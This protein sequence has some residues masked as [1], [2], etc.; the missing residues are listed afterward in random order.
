MGLTG[1][2]YKCEV[3]NC[4][5]NGVLSRFLTLWSIRDFYIL[6]YFTMLSSAKCHKFLILHVE[7]NNTS[8]IFT[9]L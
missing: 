9:I 5:T 8:S 1:C 4:V 3:V 6:I 7:F 2:M